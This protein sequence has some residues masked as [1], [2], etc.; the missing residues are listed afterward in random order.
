MKKIVS[1]SLWGSNPKYTD[2]AIKNA[3]DVQSFYPGWL[4]RFYVAD[5]VPEDVL[6]RLE[7]LG[8]EVKRM[9][10]T[11]DVLGMYWRF[12]PIYD[13][14]EVERFI[15]RDTDSRFTVREVKMVNE[16]VE[17]GKDYT[18]SET[19]DPTIYL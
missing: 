8:A 6:K 11:T 1:F 5:D 4:C 14:A 16:W 7:E 15:V 3:E 19:I 9:G 18:S 2:G 17:S 13:D 10:T 12:H